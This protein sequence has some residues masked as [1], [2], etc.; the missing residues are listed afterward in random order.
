MELLNLAK[1]AYA[2]IEVVAGQPEVNAEKILKF[3]AQAK[4]QN[5]ELIVFPELCLS[6]KFIG[7]T[8]R[9]KSFLKDCD[10]FGKK[11]VAASDGITVI[12][13]NLVDAENKNINCTDKFKF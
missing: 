10:Y 7:D 4:A 1:I 12:F 13:G 9:Q 8:S 3:I 2:Q 5:I 11:I 6:G